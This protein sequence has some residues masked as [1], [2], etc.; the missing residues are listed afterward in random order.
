MTSLFV[1]LKPLFVVLW[2]LLPDGTADS[3]EQKAHPAGHGHE[4]AQPFFCGVVGAGGYK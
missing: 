1:V 2:D 3:C 4:S